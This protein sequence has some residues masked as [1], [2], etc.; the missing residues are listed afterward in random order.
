MHE[1]FFSLLK[2]KASPPST[3]V[4]NRRLLGVFFCDSQTDK[5]IFKQIFKSR[6]QR[7]L[8]KVTSTFPEV[9]IKLLLGNLKWPPS[10]IRCYLCE[11]ANAPS[12]LVRVC[13][14]HPISPGPCTLSCLAVLQTFDT[15]I[16]SSHPQTFSFPYQEIQL[17]PQ[18]GWWFSHCFCPSSSLAAFRSS[19][20][21][22][23]IGRHHRLHCIF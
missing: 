16:L 1:F 12:F 18:L 20:P 23:V 11:I 17:L 21:L 13:D 4:A 6:D 9:V 5:M 3:D 22:R 19:G 7:N 2:F 15:S 8:N 10:T 14:F